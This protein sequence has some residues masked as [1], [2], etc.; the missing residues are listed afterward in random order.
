MP[1]VVRLDPSDALIVEVLHTDAFNSNYFIY[2]ILFN[3]SKYN[4]IKGRS[5]GATTALGHMDFYI[6]G[7]E[8]QPNCNQSTAYPPFTKIDRNALKEGTILPACSHKRAFKYY[9]EALD[10]TECQF[11][12]FACK[13]YKDFIEVCVVFKRNY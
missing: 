12:G 5:Q 10:N 3:K 7:A 6:N 4:K 8:L 1:A 9:I 13:N 11:I 2:N